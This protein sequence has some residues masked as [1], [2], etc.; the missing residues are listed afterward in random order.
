MSFNIGTF[1]RSK[2]IKRKNSIACEEN[3]RN[4]KQ[5]DVLLVLDTD[6]IER[7]NNTITEKQRDRKWEWNEGM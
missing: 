5:F 1:K 3:I 2:A 6:V 7:G 4:N